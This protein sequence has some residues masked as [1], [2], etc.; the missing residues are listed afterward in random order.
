MRIA[1]RSACRKFSERAARAAAGVL[2]EVV[3]PGSH[4]GR[5]GRRHSRGRRREDGDCA[6]L[7][8]SEDRRARS[9]KSIRR[10][11]RTK[12]RWSTCRP[13][14]KRRG[15]RCRSSSSARPRR[16]QTVRGYRKTLAESLVIAD[17]E[18]A[19]KRIVA[20]SERAVPWR[21]GGHQQH[22]AIARSVRARSDGPGRQDHRGPRRADAG[23]EA[24][25]AVRLQRRRA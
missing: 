20:A 7:R 5:R 13:T 3:S 4:G 24:R 21:A 1:C 19:A 6:F 15:G 16:D 8:H 17:V 14:R 12:R 9:R 18:P 25:A 23:S 11:R 10:C 22:R 2:P